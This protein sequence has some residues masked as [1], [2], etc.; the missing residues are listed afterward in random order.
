MLA[1]ADVGALR[2]VIL[3]FHAL[4][5]EERTLESARGAFDILREETPRR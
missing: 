2:A 1:R 4:P 3:A 5:E